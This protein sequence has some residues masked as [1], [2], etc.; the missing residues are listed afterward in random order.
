MNIQNFIK[1]FLKNQLITYVD[2]GAADNISKRWGKISKNL[3]FIGFE[4]NYEEYIKIKNKN[5]AK[6]KLFN[7]AVGDKNQL[8]KLNILKST[9]ASSFLKPNFKILKDY[10]NSDRFKLKKKIQLKVKKIDSLKLRQIDF[11]KIDTQGFNLKVLKGAEKSL[12][13]VLGLEI[14]TEFVKIYKNQYLFEDIKKYLEKKNFFFVNFYNLRRWSHSKDYFYGKSIFCN[15]LFLKK[16]DVNDLKNYNKLIK[17]VIICILYNVLDIA[18]L[19]VV[20]SSITS[21]QK[22]T[23]IKYL[24][25]LNKKFFLTK[26]YISIYNRVCRFF[27]IESELFPTF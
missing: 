1:Q 11:L 23:I 17:Y 13:S 24:K 22:K 25:K 19:I 2:V 5:F 15:S 26:I 20:K 9:F 8:G 18:H 4:P 7:F 27:N 16:L 14:E 12:D 21:C 10:P 3:K 6:F